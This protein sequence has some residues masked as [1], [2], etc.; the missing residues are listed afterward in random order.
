[1]SA[2]KWKPL[3]LSYFETAALD[4]FSSSDNCSWVSPRSFLSFFKF[5]LKSI[6]LIP[7]STTLGLAVPAFILESS[8]KDY[9]EMSQINMFDR[10][11]VFGFD[12]NMDT[13]ASVLAGA[14]IG[15]F[16]GTLIPILHLSKSEGLQI[17]PQP[18]GVSVQ[19]KF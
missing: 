8:P 13:M 6:L 3:P 14:F 1:M 7:G 17:V 11:L 18:W 5:V 2:S 12:K 10:H 9:K 4:I 15:S 16:F 19:L